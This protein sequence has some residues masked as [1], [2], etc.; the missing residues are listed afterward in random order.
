MTGSCIVGSW[1]PAMNDPIRSNCDQQTMW[2]SLSTMQ[3]CRA[4]KIQ[5]YSTIARSMM[6]YDL[7]HWITDMEWYG[8]IWWFRPVHGEYPSRHHG[9]RYSRSS[10]TRMRDLGLGSPWPRL[11]CDSRSSFSRTSCPA[12]SLSTSITRN[13]TR[14]MDRPTD[15]LAAGV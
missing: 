9:F 5:W 11:P 8:L 4:H 10:M 2:P 12:S 7:W 15:F 14:I 6:I 1:I 3:Q 13:R